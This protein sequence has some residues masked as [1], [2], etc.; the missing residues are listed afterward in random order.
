MKVWQ[1]TVLASLWGTALHSTAAKIQHSNVSIPLS[2]IDTIYEKEHVKQLH[3]LRKMA[4]R[5]KTIPEFLQL[6]QHPLSSVSEIP[7][8]DQVIASK[9]LATYYGEIS[10]GS[11]PERAFKVLFDTGSC[12]F[13]VPDETCLSM[14]C[15]G[16]TKY[17]RSASFQ[18]RFNQ[19]GK[20]SLMNVVYLSGTLQGYDGY[21][22]VHLGNGISVPHT[23][24][25]FGT[26]VDIPLLRD[27]AWDGIVGLGFKN[28]EI[29]SR[30][31]VPFL[32][33]IVQTKALESKHLGNQFAY[34]LNA[35]G[36]S[37]TFGGAD[38]SKKEYP[39]EEF[40][41]IPVDPSDS[42]WTVKVI[43]V[44][45]EPRSTSS[46]ATVT[47]QLENGQT[48]V[49][50]T[51]GKKSIVDTGTYLIYA[52]AT[53]MENELSD[54]S[55]SSCDDKKRLPDLILQ[56][57]GNPQHGGDSVVEV[58]LSPDDYVLEFLEDDGSRECMLGI[59]MDD[60]AEED[61]LDGWTLGQVFLRCY[62]TVFDRDNLQIGF[63]R[64]KH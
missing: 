16:H 61:A 24:I 64:A 57:L 30:G 46:L 39:T 50:Q 40:S 3:Q 20:P 48:A 37:M 44:H 1:L 53:V 63:A 23:N 52:P 8:H 15:I 21:D 38:L 41:W 55:V 26:L 28:H 11:E 43:G 12:E 62:Y 31:V 42:Y 2:K 32:D 27:L 36:G 19:N 5:M 51:D 59:A 4:N 9:K 33:H 47:K 45:K 60:A 22:T 34:Y 13:W 49:T 35:D 54:I 58:R 25:G 6:R 29:S 10:I 7:L 18:P 56:F 14:Q 17:R